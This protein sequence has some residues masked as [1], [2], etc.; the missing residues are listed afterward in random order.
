MSWTPQQVIASTISGNIS[1]PTIVMMTTEIMS[2]T[3]TKP[4]LSNESDEPRFP[5]PNNPRRIAP[6]IEVPMTTITMRVIPGNVVSRQTGG[7]GHGTVTAGVDEPLFCTRTFAQT[8]EASMM[9][10]TTD[11]EPSVNVPPTSIEFP[12]ASKLAILPPQFQPWSSFDMFISPGTTRFG[13]R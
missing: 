9:F 12:L 6:T 3:N 1:D 8:L 7:T 5:V 2:R 13:R 11:T 4:P 10:P